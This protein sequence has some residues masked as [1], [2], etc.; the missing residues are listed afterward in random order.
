MIHRIILLLLLLAVG[1]CSNVPMHEREHLSNRCM[2]WNQS[3]M[4]TSLVGDQFERI[5]TN[6]DGG[7]GGCVGCAK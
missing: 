3:K 7:G 5:T 4:I 2:K 6:G 1:S